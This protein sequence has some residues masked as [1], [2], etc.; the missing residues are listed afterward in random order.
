MVR[1]HRRQHI[2]QVHVQQ[3]TLQQLEGFQ[4]DTAAHQQQL[5]ALTAFAIYVLAV[6]HV[7]VDHRLHLADHLA[8]LLGLPVVRSD[9]AHAV[10]RPIPQH[11]L[12]HGLQTWHRKQRR[13]ARLDVRVLQEEERRQQ[14][15]E[16][17][18][19][20]QWGGL[21]RGT[22]L[23]KGQQQDAT[24]Q[25]RLSE[26]SHMISSHHIVSIELEVSAQCEHR[27]HREHI[28][29]GCEPEREGY[30]HAVQVEDAFGVV[31]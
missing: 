31:L 17:E 21:D 18:E 27:Q 30:D 23:A 20:E 9:S 1:R 12:A 25:A 22:T 8:D 14:E 5:R 24:E 10:H 3:V 28:R 2:R 15:E 19:Q 29:G 11:A 26:L 16:E 7:H 4:R 13:L 6:V